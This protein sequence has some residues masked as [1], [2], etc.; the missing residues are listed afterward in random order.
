MAGLQFQAKR[1]DGFGGAPEVT[2][3]AASDVTWVRLRSTRRKC[4]QEHK[5]KQNSGNTG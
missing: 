2:V 4:Y 1:A 5:P 3:A